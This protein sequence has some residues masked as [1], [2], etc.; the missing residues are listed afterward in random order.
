MWVQPPQYGT[1]GNRHSL[2][3][4][5]TYA[6]ILVLLENVGVRY[7][8]YIYMWGRGEGGRGGG[9][10][11]KYNAKMHMGKQRHALSI[12]IYVLGFP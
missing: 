12:Y 7:S 11:N 3:I 1:C 6:Q 10:I 9:C 4:Y 8:T 2:V 5:T